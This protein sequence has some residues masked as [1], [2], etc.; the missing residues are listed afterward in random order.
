MTTAETFFDR[1][2]C[3]ACNEAGVNVFERPYDSEPLRSALMAFYADV[4]GL[5]FDVLR[6]ETYR[7]AACPSCR[8]QFQSRVPSDAVLGSLYEEWIDPELARARHDQPKSPY[9]PLFMAR[10][11]TVALANRGASAPRTALDYGC[12]WGEWSLMGRAFG[13]DCWATELSPSRRAHARALGIH[14]VDE[15]QLPPGAFGLV[16]ID[17]VLEHVP[18]PMDTLAQI[19]RTMHPDGILRLAVPHAR[20]VKSALANFDREIARPRLGDVNAIAPL[21]HLNAFTHEGL[22]RMAAAVGLQRALPTWDSLASTTVF[23]RGLVAKLK[24]VALPMY[25]RGNSTTHLL[26]RTGPASGVP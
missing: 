25:L 1:T 20:R 9:A 10:D 3:P 22:I 18:A 16:S 24:A 6:S 8:T 21:E 13:L 17:Q 15:E 14:V 5:D 23:P 7:V 26:F 11:M 4:G 19:A 2:N 12:G